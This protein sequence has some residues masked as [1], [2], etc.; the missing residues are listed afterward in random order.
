MLLHRTGWVSFCYDKDIFHLRFLH[1]QKHF[2]LTPESPGYPCVL[3]NSESTRVKGLWF[4]FF[5][6][7]FSSRW[8]TSKQHSL[9]TSSDQQSPDLTALSPGAHASRHAAFPSL[10]KEH[11]QCQHRCPDFASASCSTADGGELWQ[12]L[13]EHQA[14]VVIRALA[15]S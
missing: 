8:E 14:K 11:A 13:P 2:S 12:L 1:I 15:N 7:S 9:L 6:N 5:K 3:Q 4:D 10:Q